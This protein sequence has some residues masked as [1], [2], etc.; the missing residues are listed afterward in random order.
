MIR[1]RELFAYE[2]TLAEPLLA[3]CTYPW[4]ILDQL[5][6]FILSLQKNLDR[7]AY[8]ELAPQVFVHKSAQIYPNVY[9]AG[10]T[11]IGPETEL[12]P[13]AFLRG[14]VLAGRHCVIGNSTE[15]KNTLFL[16]EVQVPHYNYTGDS[17]FGLHSHMGAG[18][19][20]SN[21]KGDHGP[22]LVKDAA[23]VM[24]SGRRKF[25]AILG[26]GVEVGC[27]SVL[28]PGTIIG[29]GSR[30]YPLSLVRGVIPAR[31]IL[32][33]GGILIPLEER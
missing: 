29:K 9:F 26:D 19:I 28:N 11:I 14:A 20:T 3:A 2:G 32:K 33:T 22:V 12:R 4:E 10:P 18:A 23:E 21:V 7:D 24:P 31:H 8:L 16:G 15:A 6:D 30:I 17:V 1:T 27:N 25:G 13:G 5:R